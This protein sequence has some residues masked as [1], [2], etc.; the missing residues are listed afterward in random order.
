MANR[1]IDFEILPILSTDIH[2]TPQLLTKAAINKTNNQLLVIIVNTASS[3]CFKGVDGERVVVILR[4]TN[5]VIFRA[6][7]ISYHKFQIKYNTPLFRRS[8]RC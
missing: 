4:L 2:R 7:M 1:T 6:F 5:R 8:L 3:H